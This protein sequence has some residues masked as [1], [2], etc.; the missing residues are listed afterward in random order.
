[1]GP[2][3]KALA[4]ALPA[5]SLVLLVARIIVSTEPKHRGQSLSYWIEQHRRFNV[6][7]ESPLAFRRAVNLNVSQHPG[8]K[9]A[10]AAI[11]AIG[12]PALAYLIEWMRYEPPNL[13]SRFLPWAP[14]SLRNKVDH[15]FFSQKRVNRAEAALQ[16]LVVLGTNAAPAIP[17]LAALARKDKNSNNYK[18]RRAAITMSKLGPEAL[19]AMLNLW[20][21]CIPGD[22]AF[23]S[24]LMDSQLF[25]QPL[26]GWPP[27]DQYDAMHSKNQLPALLYIMHVHDEP[28]RSAA[29]NAVWCLDPEL[30]TNTPA[31]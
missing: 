6:F 5:A 14:L 20:S 23:L 31:Q 29:S 1:V 4:L 22:K 2:R 25:P 9:E 16:A 7:G 15:A 30:L 3:T 24:A 17:A 13:G 8:L 12:T 21:N 27:F 28:F 26:L 19:P 18:A 10:R 11:R